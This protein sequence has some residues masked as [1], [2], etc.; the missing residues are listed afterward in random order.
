MLTEDQKETLIDIADESNP[1]CIIITYCPSCGKKVVL[2]PT[3]RSF[4]E[5]MN[6]FKHGRTECECGRKVWPVL[7]VYS[8][9]K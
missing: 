1:E 8:K 3:V 5:E 9:D 6:S 2:E 7:S 4:N